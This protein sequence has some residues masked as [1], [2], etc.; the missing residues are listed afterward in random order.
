[1]LTA[2]AQSADNVARSFK[3][4]AAYFIPKEEMA[5]IETFLEDILEAQKKGQSTWIGWY[6]RL[7]AYGQRT[8]GSDFAEENDDFLE[9]LIKY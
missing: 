7:A 6:N 4:G 1:M 2:R 3:E 5:R 9:K 8:F